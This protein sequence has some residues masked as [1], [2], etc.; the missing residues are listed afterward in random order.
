MSF[1]L[2]FTLLWQANTIITGSHD[3]TAMGS[4]N[5]GPVWSMRLII[6]ST[7]LAW[8]DPSLG[9]FGCPG[10]MILV[11]HP[12]IASYSNG[13]SLK[14]TE[15]ESEHDSTSTPNTSTREFEVLQR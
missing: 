7:Y 14:S 3:D 6:L 12:S 2:T 1:F 5:R 9:F 8:L 13:A 15:K 4:G 11:P 10:T